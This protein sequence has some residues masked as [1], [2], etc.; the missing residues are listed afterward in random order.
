MTMRLRGWGTELGNM[1]WVWIKV[2]VWDVLTEISERE[3][4][5]D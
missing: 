2:G 4:E 3:G 5:G 1:R